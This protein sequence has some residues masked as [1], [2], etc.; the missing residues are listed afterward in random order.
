MI[1]FGLLVL[2]VVTSQAAMQNA[3][4]R[5]VCGFTGSEFV[6]RQEFAVLDTP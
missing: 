4:N 3:G 5:N 1:T 2:Y 6:W